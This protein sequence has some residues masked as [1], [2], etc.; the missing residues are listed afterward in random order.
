MDDLSIKVKIAG[1]EYPMTVKSKEEERVRNAAKMLNEKMKQY[2][3]QY[4]IEDKQ[5]LLAMAAFDLSVE[6]LSETETSQKTD[7]SVADKINYLNQLV[8]QAL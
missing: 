5:D 8:S 4:Q 6:K 3:I 2:Q 1:R 7:N